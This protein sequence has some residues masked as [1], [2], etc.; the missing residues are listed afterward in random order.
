MLA[1]G[2]Y[3]MTN[4]KE[5]YAGEFEITSGKAMVSDPCY[6]RETWCQGVID[7]VKNGTWKAYLHIIDDRVGYILCHHKSHICL[8]NN[9][10]T[11]ES[12]EVGVDSGQAGVYDEPKYH[13]GEDDYGEGGWYDLNCNLTCDKDNKTVRYGGVL[14]GGV[15]SSSGY[16]DGGYDCSTIKNDG[17]IVGI[18]VDF[19]LNED[20]DYDEEW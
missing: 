18:L 16:G 10:W 12:F 2:G 20:I 19:G 3:I 14:E 11:K 8:L 4:S 6:D 1:N 5:S 7:N 9:D 15:V 17:E 13:G